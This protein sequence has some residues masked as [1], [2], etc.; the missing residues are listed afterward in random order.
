MVLS[1]KNSF[2]YKE[3]TNKGIFAL[4]LRKPFPFSDR[5][6]NFSPVGF[7]LP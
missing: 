4:F 7:P 6:E 3:N 5:L 2:L 1:I